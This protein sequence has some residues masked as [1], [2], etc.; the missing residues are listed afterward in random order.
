MSRTVIFNSRVCDG[1]GADI[2][3]QDI[4]LENDTISAVAQP[5]AFKDAD[6]EFIDAENLIVSPGFIDAHSHGE[7]RKLQYPENRTKFLQG[8]TTEV[9][10]NCGYSDACV[11]GEAAGSKWNDLAEYAQVINERKI[12]TNTVVLC[13]HNS[14]RNAVMG[15]AS[16]TASAEEN[17]AMQL[18]L[19][20]ALEQ[21]A[22]GWSTG[23]TYFP[24]KFSDLAE[25]TSLGECIRGSKKVYATHMRSEGDDLISALDEA[26]AVAA[27]GSGILQIS[28]IK[29][30]FPRNYHKLDAM[31]EKIETARQN[32]LTVYADRYPYI[33]SS[34][35]IRQTLPEPYCKVVDIAD[36]LRS[37]TAYQ[38]EVAAALEHSPRDLATTI[39]TAK[40]MTLQAIAQIKNCSI[41]EAC[42][43]EIMENPA[44]NA[45]YLCMS[46]SNLQRI[47]SLPWVCAGSDGISMQLDDPAQSGHPRAAGALPRFF[48]M[49]KKLCGT[50]EAVRK[51]TGL[52]AEI[53]RIPR[54]GLIKPGFIADLVIFD[55]NKL[56]SAADFGDCASAPQGIKRIMVAGKTAWTSSAPDQVQRLGRFIAV[57]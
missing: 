14:L 29:T 5:G 3:P 45:A 42:M 26:I 1:S 28:H 33:Y 31:L 56:D 47:L 57:D 21:G 7:V 36:K 16:R 15:S 4:L 25:L 44:A 55:E 32:G 13:G 11:P 41:P 39:V 12:S 20:Q 53:F 52:P 8:I 9:D 22:A 24:G 17:Q 46:E 35:A 48:R 10:G 19:A 38:A 37:S 6:A 51:M 40:N 43:L 50:A 23:L 18:M 49:T 30:I 34:T 2:R 27:A 54:R